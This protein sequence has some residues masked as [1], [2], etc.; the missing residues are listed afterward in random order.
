[1]SVVVAGLLVIVVVAT[2]VKAARHP[3][4]RVVR[5]DIASGLQPFLT[6]P[7]VRRELAHKG[8]TVKTGTQNPDFDFAMRVDGPAVF[9]TPLVAVT[10][11]AD[12]QTLAQ[13]GIARHEASGVWTIDTVQLMHAVDANQVAVQAGG[14]MSPAGSF[15]AALLGDVANNMK[16]PTDPT[17]VVNAV[18]PTF[19][20]QQ[21]AGMPVVNFAFESD[22]HSNDAVVMYPTPD[23]V[24]RA[25]I[26]AHSPAGARFANVVAT[27][28]TLQRLAPSSSVAV[29]VL[30]LPAPA[31]F[32]Q[33]AQF[34]DTGA[35]VRAA[36]P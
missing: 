30:P 19:A 34:V 3:A 27:D 4:E 31:V 23:V 29:S 14:S 2:I 21:P 26:T 32:T 20:P 33:L 6:N 25:V 17:S 28:P 7:A 13:R 10:S 18:S 15:L 11:T 1:M 9:S 12:A 36:A 24:A 5:G 8:F 16:P 35:R 22:S